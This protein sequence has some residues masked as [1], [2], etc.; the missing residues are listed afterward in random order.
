MTFYCVIKNDLKRFKT[1]NKSLN[2]LKLSDIKLNMLTSNIFVYLFEM[3][4]LKFT[5]TK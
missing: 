2:E 1:L 3:H 5:F 4:T